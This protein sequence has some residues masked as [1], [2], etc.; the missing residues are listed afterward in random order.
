MAWAEDRAIRGDTTRAPT[1]GPRPKGAARC[2]PV[3]PLRDWYESGKS[4]LCSL[5]YFTPYLTTPVSPF[6]GEPVHPPRDRLLNR[7]PHRMKVE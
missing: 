1:Q 2:R 6:H 3:F 7:K 4:I 5:V